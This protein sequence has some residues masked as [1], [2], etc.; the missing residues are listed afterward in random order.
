MHERREEGE[1]AGEGCHCVAPLKQRRCASRQAEGRDCSQQSPRPTRAQFTSPS[2]AL[3]PSLVLAL[4]LVLAV[5][6]SCQTRKFAMTA[7]IASVDV[8]ADGDGDV[9][10]VAQTKNSLSGALAATCATR[11]A[12][13]VRCCIINCSTLC[14]LKWGSRGEGGVAGWERSSLCKELEEQ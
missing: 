12:L 6:V 4:A 8:D 11:S 1:G 2:P 10:V 3:A 9:G 13:G 14:V 5:L 7:N